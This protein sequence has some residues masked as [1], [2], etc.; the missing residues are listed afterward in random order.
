MKEHLEAG[1]RAVFLEDGNVHL[2]EGPM[3]RPLADLTELKWL[4]MDDAGSQ[5][6]PI[7]AAVAAAWALGVQ[8]ELIGSALKSYVP[9]VCNASDAQPMEIQNT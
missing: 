1:G 2:A 6:T 4:E 9:R 7:L 8:A 3:H 5:A